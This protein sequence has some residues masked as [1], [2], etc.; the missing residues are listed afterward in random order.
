[1]FTA[2]IA[3]A[4][5]VIAGSLLTPVVRDWAAR[6]G[7][8][9]HALT[10]RKIHGRPVPRLGGI[11]IV[12]AFFAPLVGLLFVDSAVARIF[13]AEPRSVVGLFLGGLAV[14]ALGIYDDL[15]GTGANKKLA[16]Q[17]CVGALMYSLGFR[18][19]EI[20][21]PFGPSLPLGPLGLPFTMLWFAGVV[22]AMNLIDG[23][24]GLAG[25]VALIGLASSFVLAL[26]RGDPLMMLLCAALAGAVLGF[27]FY[28]F[29]P[30][31]IFMGDTGSMFLGFV[32]AAAGVQMQ[33]SSGAAVALLT[34]VVALGLPIGDTLLAMLRR[35][36]R[37]R[38]M[39]QADREHIHHLLLA[40]GLSHRGACLALYAVAVVL[41][42]A[43]LLLARAASG[44]TAVLILLPL[45]SGSALF[46]RW[47][48]FARIDR[49][50]EVVEL[51]RR[52][53]EMRS[54]MRA[55]AESLRSASDPIEVW[56]ALREAAPVLGAECIAVRMTEEGH[57]GR[58]LVEFSEGFGEGRPGVF[59]ARY[60][61]APERLAE[62]CLELGWTDRDAID[63]DT[64][65]AVE[66]LCAQV[67]SSFDR[68]DRSRPEE[69][70]AE[71][72]PL[73]RR[74]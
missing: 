4:I 30:A 14:A 74:A 71:V 68:I 44:W 18:I 1:M 7:L 58:R 50:P 46:L 41:G 34:P 26:L 21:N 27:L 65:I 61:I 53:L 70:G 54:G 60:G 2:A 8:L 42:V 49:V 56:R 52:N 40:K 25:G 36:L 29:N 6:W 64:E 62:A 73:R 48:G 31:S 9:D 33:H 43:A 35:L 63:R 13:R 38:P 3:F 22:N 72:V 24:D 67:A 16:V 12:V 10:S 57:R 59:R 51:R 45:V 32:L 69:S 17:L 20:A 19:D 23:L 47:L 55:V 39:F 28:N 66:E 15:R 11:A 5:S 37:G